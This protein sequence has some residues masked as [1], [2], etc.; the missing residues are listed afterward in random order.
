MIIE[1]RS[2]S[3]APHSSYITRLEA[4]QPTGASSVDGPA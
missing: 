2:I 1:A 4:K 3:L